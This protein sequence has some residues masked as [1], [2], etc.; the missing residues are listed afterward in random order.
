MNGADLSSSLRS[1]KLLG[2]WSTALGVFLST[3]APNS[4]YRPNPDHYGQLI[5]VM[6][7]SGRVDIVARLA[8]VPGC[9]PL[10]I[11]IYNNIME[12]YS[13]SGDWQS[14]AALLETMKKQQQA[15]GGAEIPQ[16]NNTTYNLLITA[17]ETAKQWE[18]A[19]G[20]LQEMSSG[21]SS[22]SVRPD[23]VTYAVVVSALEVSHQY[24]KAQAVVALMPKE[25][26][27]AILSSYAAL[28]HVWSVRHKGHK[29][30]PQKKK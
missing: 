12:S 13:K 7:E 8:T 19:L 30:L 15:G 28:I 3:L 20:V 16:P 23:S 24:E 27:D 10:S 4:P 2:D 18:L 29:S 25:D 1:A 22:T 6:S 14:G 9:P 5:D 17:M 26:R 21:S 11:D